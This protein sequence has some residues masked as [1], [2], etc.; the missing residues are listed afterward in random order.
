MHP[1]CSILR[2]RDDGTTRWLSG[3]TTTSTMRYDLASASSL[4]YSNQDEGDVFKGLKKMTKSRNKNEACPF[5]IPTIVSQQKDVVVVQEEENRQDDRPQYH[6]DSRIGFICVGPSTL[7][8][9][10]ES[11]MLGWDE[12]SYGYHGDDGSTFHRGKSSSDEM[13]LPVLDV[14][15]RLDVG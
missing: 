7:S 9:K 15:I 6:E 2:E 4:W 1:V 14:V 3:I 11:N 10:L 12:H 13:V 8:S 5:V